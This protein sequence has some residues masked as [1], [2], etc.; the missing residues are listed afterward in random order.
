[1]KKIVMLFSLVFSQII[2]AETVEIVN[3][4][5]LEIPVSSIMQLQKFTAQFNAPVKIVEAYADKGL[6]TLYVSVGGLEE[7]QATWQLPTDF[8]DVDSIDFQQVA[9]SNTSVITIKGTTTPSNNGNEFAHKAV[10]LKVSVNLSQVDGETQ[11]DPKLIV[12]IK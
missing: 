2:C 5:A 4:D 10:E 9:N 8:T 7:A 1:M 11:I 6:S 12:E 3:E